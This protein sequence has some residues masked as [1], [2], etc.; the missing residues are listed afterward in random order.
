MGSSDIR[1]AEIKRVPAFFCAES[2]IIIIHPKIIFSL[3]FLQNFTFFMLI[4][5]K[6]ILE[7]IL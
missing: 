5:P 2:K 6:R 1:G 3:I 4:L 7:K